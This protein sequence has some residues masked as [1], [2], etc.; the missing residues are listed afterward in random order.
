VRLESNATSRLLTARAGM[1][2]AGELDRYGDR[3]PTLIPIQ[4]LQYA[5]L[6]P[7]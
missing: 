2:T 6:P 7:A 5:S 3:H 4:H 1:S